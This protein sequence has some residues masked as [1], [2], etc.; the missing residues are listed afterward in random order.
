MMNVLTLYSKSLNRLKKLCAG[1]IKESRS[2]TNQTC[3]SFELHENH[4][5][6]KNNSHEHSAGI[7]MPKLQKEFNVF[8]VELRHAM[9]D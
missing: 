1:G 6:K 2:R 7:E 3:K 8:L 5:F 9:A 4:K